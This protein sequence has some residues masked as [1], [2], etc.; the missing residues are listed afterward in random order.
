MPRDTYRTGEK[1]RHYRC[2]A[3][4]VGGFVQQ[5]AV[6][7]LRHGY[8]FWVSGHIKDGKDPTKVDRKLVEKYE[9]Y[10]T[11]AERARRKRRGQANAQYLRHGRFWLVIVT[12]GEHGFF[13]AVEDG[14]ESRNADGVELGYRDAQRQPIRYAGYSMSFRMPRAR[15][16]GNGDPVGRRGHLHVGIEKSE[17]LRLRA[18]LEELAPRRSVDELAGVFQSLPFE[19]YAAV[20]AQYFALFRR[21]NSVRKRAGKALV[22]QEA[23]RWQ[24]RIYRPFEAEVLDSDIG[25]E[26]MA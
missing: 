20:S 1:V 4:S 18:W 9:C 3:T 17:Y 21:V 14:G 7:Y 5:L 6:S 11:S 2:V 10:W 8:R 25:A 16:D 19:P 26:G 23:V 13:R 12:P 22:P 15:V 24:R